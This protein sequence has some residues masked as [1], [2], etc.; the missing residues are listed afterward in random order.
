[1][2]KI[3]LLLFLG[4]FLSVF[5]QQKT[6]SLDD[7]VLGYQKGLNPASLN[8]LKWVNNSNSYV[9]QKDNALIF[10][11]AVSNKI[12][13]NIPLSDLQKSYPELTRFPRLME[14]STNELVF[15]NKNFIET[16]NHS[17]LSKSAS[18]SFDQAAENK[19]YNAKAKAIAYTLNNNLFIGT[20]AN[21]KIA[22]TSI[23]DK[24]T[25]SGQ[26][27]HRSEFGIVKGTFWSPEGNYLAFYQKDESNVT[28]YPLVDITTYP[29]SLKNIKYPM[30]GQESEIAKIGIYNLQTQQTVYLDIDTSDEH[31]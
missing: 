8:D 24:N 18:N 7:A 19:E 16:F 9:F 20:A 31:Y 5:S 22:V 3:F 27:I 11:D 2:K 15:V 1:M 10:T 21:P 26:A 6:L 25:V 28:D 12:T 23:E 29:A 30:A 14:I 4:T 17:N 13:K